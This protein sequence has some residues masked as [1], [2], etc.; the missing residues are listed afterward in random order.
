MQALLDSNFSSILAN[1]ADQ[2][3]SPVFFANAAVALAYPT[4]S[5]LPVNADPTVLNQ[6][7]ELRDTAG[8]VQAS[9]SF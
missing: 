7:V 8:N 6:T 4:V 2:S 9:Y 1:R 3:W 5:G